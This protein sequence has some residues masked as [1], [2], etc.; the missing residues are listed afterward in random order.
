MTWQTTLPLVVQLLSHNIRLTKSHLIYKYP[1]PLHTEEPTYWH[2]DIAN[3]TN[4][5][6]HAGPRMEIKVAFLL[7]DC[8]VSGSGNTILAPGSNLLN[9]PLRRAPGSEDPTNV[10][11]PRLKAGDAFLFE[12]R[13]YHRQSANRSSKIRK[14]FMIGYSY[15]WLAP[16]DYV[17]QSPNLLR[18]ITDPIAGQL[19]G[20]RRKPN[21]QIDDTPLREW[22]EKH[23]VKHA[24]EMTEYSEKQV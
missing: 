22:A 6:G 12:N 16:N 8:L 4:D 19:L 10:I 3:S 1:D 20:A 13:T 18:R 14:V 21:T 24:A 15:A 5:I 11:E 17:V 23:G 2:R 7:S 9:E